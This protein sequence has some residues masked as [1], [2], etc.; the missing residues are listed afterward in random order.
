MAFTEAIRAIAIKEL[1]DK[2]RSRW[3]LVVA[4]SFALLT[5]VIAYFGSAPAGIAGFRRLDATV[6]SLTSLVTFFI[7][8]IALTLGGGIIADER[9]R[10]TLEILLASPVSVGEFILGKFSGLVIALGIA[11]V[12]GLCL[13]GGVLLIKSGME[14]LGVFLRFIANSLI[15]GIVFLSISFLVSIAFYE[16]TK[17]IAFTVLIWLL[18]TILYDLGLV[19]L[20]LLTKGEI[21]MGVFSLLLMFNPVDV[22][23]IMNF[24][25]IGEFRVFLG[26][27]SVEFPEYVGL[28]MLLFVSLGWIVTPLVGGYYFFKKKYHG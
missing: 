6:A 28:P 26:L 20:I 18:F 5:I 13:A 7:P 17:V 10:G 22:Y 9:E 2:L 8:I 1:S 15:L 4:G 19:G 24:V 21:G 14:A 11:T 3:V 27:A 25:S 12:S 23:R 16:R